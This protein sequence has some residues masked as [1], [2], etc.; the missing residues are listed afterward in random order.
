[1]G[2]VQYDFENAGRYSL[3]IR[4]SLSSWFG[5]EST[6]TV[7]IVPNTPTP[8]A[9]ES[10]DSYDDAMTITIDDEAQ[11]HNFHQE[12]DEDW[13]LLDLERPET[14]TVRTGEVHEHIIP[15]ITIYDT[16]R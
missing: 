8:D 14:L 13:V 9:Y 1:V 15:A 10:D 16:N 6:Y 12:G 4:E 5:I 7:R 2:R 11:V 3:K